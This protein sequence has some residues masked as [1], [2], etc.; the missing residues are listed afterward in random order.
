MS[1]NNE[2]LWGSSDANLFFNY[3][4]VSRGKTVT[5]YIWNAG[6]STSYAAHS[7]GALTSR[8]D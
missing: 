7:L 8:G 4:A 2:F 6:S 5:T 1:S 3:R